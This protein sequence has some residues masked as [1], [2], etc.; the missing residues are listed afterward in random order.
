MSFDEYIDWDYEGG[1]VEWVEGVSEYAAAG[2][3]EYWLI[4][5][6]TPFRGAEFFVLPDG[7]FVPA[8]VTVGVY[9]SVVADGF[10]FRPEWLW[11]QAV[12]STDALREILDGL[13]E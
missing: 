11:D 5:S 10:W 7:E 3:R 6:R 2:V 13:P 12:R 1:L 8:P 4:E 9:R